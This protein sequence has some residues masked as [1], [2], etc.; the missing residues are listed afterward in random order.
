[1]SDYPKAAMSRPTPDFSAAHALLRGE[2]DAPRLAGVS[3]GLWRDG[4]VLDAFCTGWAD[5]EQAIP[6]ALDTVHRAFS[7]S[8]LMTSVLALRLVDAGLLALDEPVST[9]LPPLAHLRV[10]RPGAT[11][12][13]QTQA[14]EQAI[15]LRH[16]LS[17]Q[18]GFSHG[19]FDP[20]SLIF[21]GYK[22]LGVRRPDTT[23]A[24]MI[25]AMAQLPLLY[26]PGQGW[27]YSM[28]TDVLARVIEVVTGQTFG[29]ALQT[30][31][32]GPL[33]MV[34]SGFVLRPD[35]VPR[36]AALYGGNLADPQQ[37]GL[38]RLDDLPWRGAYLSPVARQ[39]GAGGLFTTQADM[40]RLLQQL[41]PGWSSFLQ[42]ATLAEALR[43]QLPPEHSVRFEQT[44]AIPSLGFGLAGA[45][46]RSAS[47]LQPNTPV[48]E[49]QW[50]GLAGTHWWVDPAS[51]LVGAM[52]TQRYFGF[53]N[54]FWYA[55]KQEM[56][57]A[58]Q[59]SDA[60]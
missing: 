52:M 60:A 14:L 29:E 28:A 18:A 11:A 50:G 12:L 39:S 1:M 57:A 35:Q 9:W 23:L 49:C 45:I 25:D 26:Q 53:W 40:L 37:S 2:V 48:G 46:T 13:D 55:Y 36:F 16:L 22:A 43:D 7:N 19:V 5:R 34:D 17:H 4:Q 27:E 56:Y 20:G 33:G 51:G 3:V 8:K 38:Q 59:A 31:L 58:L 21:E 24:Q 47:T 10:L 30:G 6:L 44:G 32:F 41:L 42:P 15:T 54:P